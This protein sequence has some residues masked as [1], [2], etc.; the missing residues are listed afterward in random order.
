MGD[1]NPQNKQIEQLY[2]EMYDIMYVYAKNTLDNSHLAEQ[3]N[4]H[5]AEEATQDVFCIACAKSNELLQSSN[6]KGWLMQTLKHVIQNIKRQQAKM[7]KQAILSLT[8]EESDLFATYDEENVDIL[9][10][11]V[12]KRKDFQIF[13]LIALENYTIKEAAEEFG[14]TFEAC[15]KRVQRI[16][17]YLRNKFS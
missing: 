5:L 7:K 6:P 15:K 3:D 11:D 9:Y 2:R 17:K 13:K 12:A 8:F 10:G 1:D 4:S 14:I 16:R